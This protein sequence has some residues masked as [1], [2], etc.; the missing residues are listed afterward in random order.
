MSF[1]GA[2]VVAATLAVGGCGASDNSASSDSKGAAAPA[3]QKPG[4]DSGTGGRA[5]PGSGAEQGSGADQDSGARQP[6]APK[7]P[8]PKAPSQLQLHVIRTAELQ[9]Q[10]SDATQA[11]V[12]ARTTAESAGGLVGN[13]STE[14]D[15]TGHVYSRI[16]LR[17][18]QDKYAET[19]T[20]LEQ[21]G[22]KLLARKADAKDVTNEVVDVESRIKSQRVS[23]A[24]VQEFMNRATKLTDV[25]SLEAELATRQAELDSL[26]AQQSSLKDR[27]SMATI[28]LV[29][30]ETPPKKK[31]TPPPADDEP[32]FLDALDGGWEA[33]VTTVRW[34][35]MVVGAVAPFA[36]TL[37]LLY[38]LWRR[39][40]APRLAPRRTRRAPAFPSYPSAYPAPPGQRHP[41]PSAPGPRGPESGAPAPTAPTAPA[42]PEGS[43]GPEG[44]ASG[45][46]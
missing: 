32:G 43:E 37:A 40:V 22:G 31:P 28:T 35:A 26:L 41:E 42:A 33:F 45:R 24:R 14:R 1:V 12:K 19:L 17:V 9:L 18:P 4:G 23:V 34:I 16:T 39:L 7:A 10:V 25:V 38:L 36:A 44:A 8:A 13:E 11:L 27:T 2:A 29:I 20:T 3:P 30:S 46:D 5:N 6:N 21:S 15:S